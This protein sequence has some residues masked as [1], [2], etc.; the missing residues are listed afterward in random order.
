MISLLLDTYAFIWYSENDPKL[1]DRLKT[2]SATVADIP[3][4]STKEAVSA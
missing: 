2:K 1:P 3:E 4:A